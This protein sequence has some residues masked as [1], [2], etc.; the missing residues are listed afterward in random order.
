LSHLVISKQEQL[1][2]LTVPS[3]DDGG[4]SSTPASDD[5]SKSCGDANAVEAVSRQCMVE[6]SADSETPTAT[7]ALA[8]VT[9]AMPAPAD[10]QNPDGQQGATEVATD[11]AG[12]IPQVIQQVT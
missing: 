10:Q 2:S 12:G 8:P 4:G 5:G 9:S 7:P 1:E 3:S 6:Q 11:S